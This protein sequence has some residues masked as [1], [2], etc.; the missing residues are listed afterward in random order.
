MT[1]TKLPALKKR[2]EA[3]KYS[4]QKVRENLDAEIFD[5]CQQEALENGHKPI[6]VWT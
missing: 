3:R 5:V 4:E 1:K 6:V 2:L